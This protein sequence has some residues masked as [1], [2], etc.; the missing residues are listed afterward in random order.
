VIDIWRREKD[1][2]KENW[3]GIDIIHMCKQM[4]LD[5]FAMMKDAYHLR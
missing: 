1:L 4:G 3:V 5:V 2:L